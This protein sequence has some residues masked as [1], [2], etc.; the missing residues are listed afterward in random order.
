MMKKIRSVFG[1]GGRL[2]DADTDNETWNRWKKVYESMQLHEMCN[3]IERER[4]G[5]KS[6]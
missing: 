2:K 5:K 3:T 1:T 6:N 4:R